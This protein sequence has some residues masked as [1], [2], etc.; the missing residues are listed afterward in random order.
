MYNPPSSEQL[1][2]MEQYQAVQELGRVTDAISWA[3]EQLQQQLLIIIQAK[4]ACD[5]ARVEMEKARAAYNRSREAV[6]IAKDEQKKIKSRLA[7][8]RDVK[9]TLHTIGRPI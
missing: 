8:L 4:L 2:S 7:M 6:E 1:Q 9:S 5:E 3:H